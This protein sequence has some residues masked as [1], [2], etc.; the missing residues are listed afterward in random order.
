MQTSSAST[1]S[2]TSRTCRRSRSTSW[3]ATWTPPVS[4]WG[5]RSF[6][7]G[8]CWEPL[9]AFS[10]PVSQAALGPDPPFCP[11]VPVPLP[12]AAGRHAPQRRAAL[13]VSPRPAPALVLGAWGS[14]TTIPEPLG[15]MRLLWVGSALY[16]I[17]GKRHP[18]LWSDQPC[19]PPGSST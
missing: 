4:R 9:P 16:D 8:R 2:S 10:S 12:G 11:Q 17:P 13:W 18:Y 5:R 3:C 6:L 19:S 14:T 7:R 15:I 1:P